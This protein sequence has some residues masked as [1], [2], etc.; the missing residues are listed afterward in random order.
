MTDVHT[1]HC[2]KHRCKYGYDENDE[3]KCTVVSG[4]LKQSFPCNQIEGC[5]LGPRII[6]DEELAE[7]NR[8]RTIRC[9][10]CRK[11]IRYT[12]DDVETRIE[13]TTYKEREVK[14]EIRFVP[15][16]GCRHDRVTGIRP[17][18]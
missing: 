2:C 13:T 14:N 8:Q 1:E 15:C 12:P 17:C 4:K 18:T 6:S 5:G 7:E 16:P 11:W 9:S 10:A 3:Q